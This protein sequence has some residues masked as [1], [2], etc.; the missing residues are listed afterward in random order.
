MRRPGKEVSQPSQ[1]EQVTNGAHKGSTA[2]ATV[3]M[4]PF[5]FSF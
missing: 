2:I 1:R 3:P 4:S 5:A